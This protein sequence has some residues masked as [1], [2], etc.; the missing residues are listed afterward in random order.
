MEIYRRKYQRSITLTPKSMDILTR[1]RWPGNVREL[2]NALEY[3]ALCCPE[4]DVVQEALFWICCGRT[5]WTR[6]CSR[7]LP[8]EMPFHIM[9]KP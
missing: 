5:L 9:K 2:E 8:W 3:L 1:Y 6:R 4:G 7:Y